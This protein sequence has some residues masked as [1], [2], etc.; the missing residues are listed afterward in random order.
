MIAQK[1]NN[2]DLTIQVG[3]ERIT[4]QNVDTKKVMCPKCSQAIVRGKAKRH[5][6][7][8]HNDGQLTTLKKRARDDED[9]DDKEDNEDDENIWRRLCGEVPSKEMESTI[10]SSSAAAYKICG[11]GMILP[12]E[13]SNL[14]Q[15]IL[16][17]EYT[18]SKLDISKHHHK[19]KVGADV[20]ATHESLTPDHLQ[21]IEKGGCD[22]LER[23]VGAILT[24]GKHQLT[25][26]CVEAYSRDKVKDPHAESHSA[27]PSSVPTDGGSTQYPGKLIIT[28]L[29]DMANNKKLVIGA[30]NHNYLV[31]SALNHELALVGPG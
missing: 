17:S 6:I 4:F 24:T 2:R 25:I 18:V 26:L 9:N 21:A 31:T 11:L 3:S 20:V 29:N 15:S 8:L 28:H 12:P 16:P 19:V 1:A 27:F 14:L 30:R 5:Y 7:S 10:E 23:I 22:G 13:T